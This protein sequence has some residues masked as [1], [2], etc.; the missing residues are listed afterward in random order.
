MAEQ[1]RSVVGFEGVYSV[2]NQGRVRRDK[3][4][5]GIV[6]G[7][8]LK[9]SLTKGGYRL[10]ILYDKPNQRAVTVHTL[11]AEAF[12]GP[13][14]PG[15]EVNHID[16]NKPNNSVGN[17]EYVTRAENTR[18]ANALGLRRYGEDW[19]CAR[20]TDEQIIELHRLSSTTSRSVLAEKFDICESY[21]YQLLAG[22]ARK[23]A[24]AKYQKE[25]ADGRDLQARAG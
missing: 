12:I 23:G 21:V 17:L 8:I 16:G 19:Y 4:G 2:S 15:Y 24:L 9:G 22:K 11:V 14:P 25:V 18:H 13:R 10:V 20:L 6:T 5:K 1:W 3:G 7:L